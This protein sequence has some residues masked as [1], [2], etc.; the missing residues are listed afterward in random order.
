MNEIFGQIT[1]RRL[2]TRSTGSNKPGSA[3][4]VDPLLSRETCTSW[5]FGHPPI[6]SIDLYHPLRNV[7]FNLLEMFTQII[8][9]YRYT[10]SLYADLPESSPSTI[11]KLE[12][13]FI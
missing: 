9:T 7:T 3:C 6:Q 5:Q 11:I 1:R 13:R 10:M 4:D 2:C 8:E 12:I